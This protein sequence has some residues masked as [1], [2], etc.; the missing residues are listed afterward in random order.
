[1]T[2]LNKDDVQQIHSKSSEPSNGN[3]LNPFVHKL[4]LVDSADKIK[5]KFCPVP[6]FTVY[7]NRHQSSEFHVVVLIYLSICTFY[8]S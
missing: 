2:Q 3:I 6:Y 7:M 8:D 5:V 1:M 4:E